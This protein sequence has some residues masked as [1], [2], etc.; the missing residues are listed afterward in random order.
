MRCYAPH[1]VYPLSGQTQQLLRSRSLRLLF[2]FFGSLQG[3]QPPNPNRCRANHQE[4][5]L[6]VTGQLDHSEQFTHKLLHRQEICT[7]WK[8]GDVGDR[9]CVVNP[10]KVQ[11]QE[12]LVSQLPMNT[13]ITEPLK[14]KDTPPPIICEC[15]LWDRELLMKMRH[16][17]SRIS[18]FYGKVSGIYEMHV[19]AGL[20]NSVNYTEQ[21]LFIKNRCMFLKGTRYTLQQKKKK[22]SSWWR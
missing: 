2:W 19:K 8:M 18:L 3:L 20:D 5:L 9:I 16:Q 4:V 22:G 14:E 17:V 15:L 6:L 13:P 7:R 21:A 12:E 11:G 10:R 1:L